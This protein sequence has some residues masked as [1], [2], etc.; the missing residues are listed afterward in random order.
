MADA[1]RRWADDEA[2]RV[3]IVCTANLCRSPIAEHLLRQANS[4]V[5]LNWAIESAGV[6]ASIGLATHP[7]AAD[8][9]AER[10]ITAREWR[11][12]RLTRPMIERA[13]L[14]LAAA[15]EHRRAVVVLDPRAAHRTFTLLQ[16]A[17]FAALAGPIS[18][19]DLAMAGN[20]L[21]SRVA[22]VRGD[23]QPVD[24]GADD[25]PD[26]MGKPLRAFQASAIQIQDA[27]DR[28]VTPMRVL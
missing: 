18:R 25:L 26:P 12:R 2:F 27:V 20:T 23:L 6:S 9:L 13:D 14:V 21:L 24:P 1:A 4:A 17:R 11:S 15:A 10:S 8:V 5:G 22:T 3:L 28:I 16:F 7:L 19:H